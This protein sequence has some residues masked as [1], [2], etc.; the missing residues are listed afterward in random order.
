[1]LDLFVSQE[2]RRKK[3]ENKT[4]INRKKEGERE[5]GIGT[6]KAKED[7]SDN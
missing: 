4:W 1:M 5:T 2:K 3:T 6:E 7:S